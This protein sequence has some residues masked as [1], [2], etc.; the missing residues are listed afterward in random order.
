MTKI[1]MEIYRAAFGA[2]FS[3]AVLTDPDGERPN[4]APNISAAKR[5]QIIA[6]NAV[7][8]AR[9]LGITTDDEID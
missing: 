4:R 9:R 2:A 7:A 1:E 3:T 8:S 5:A 6:R